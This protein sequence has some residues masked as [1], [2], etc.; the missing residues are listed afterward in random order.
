V[1]LAFLR[2]RPEDEWPLLLVSIRDE[3]LA[4]PADR[5]GRWWP[6]THPGALGGRDRRAGGTWLAVD[7]ARR[8]AAAVF[9]PGAQTAP[10]AG[11]RTRGE[12][13]LV[14]LRHGDLGSVDLAAYQPFAL[15]LAAAGRSQWWSWTG[16]HL[17]R[18]TV[19]PGTHIA[20]IDG[21]DA[22]A[23]SPRQARWRR[24]LADAAPAD[25]RADAAPADQWGGWLDLLGRGL[26][27]ERADSLVLRR[28]HDGGTYGTRSVALLAIGRDDLRYDETDQPWDPQS[29]V[30]VL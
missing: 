8:V 9:T 20:N 6:D 10:S 29:W 4:R 5:P 18:T 3:D 13:P 12:L 19:E 28:T 1:C 16:S 23:D 26:D 24:P 17:D 14:A 22:D 30:T 11:Q 21:L 7:P 27:P 25:F 15:L 2:F